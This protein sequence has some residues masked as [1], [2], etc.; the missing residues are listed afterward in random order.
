MQS[1]LWTLR[2]EKLSGRISYSGIRFGGLPP[3][4]KMHGKREQALWRKG[5]S[6]R[7]MKKKLYESTAPTSSRWLSI[8]MLGANIIMV[9]VRRQYKVMKVNQLLLIGEITEE[10]WSK[11]NSEE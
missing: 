9:V 5:P 7:K 3:R 1:R 10:D 11:S 6:I 4:T 2:G 8:V